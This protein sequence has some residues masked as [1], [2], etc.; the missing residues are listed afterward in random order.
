MIFSTTKLDDPLL[1]MQLQR[2]ASIF[3]SVLTIVP[4]Y[5]L[6]KKF[7]NSHYSLIGATLFLFE[8]HIIINSTL[9]I[10]EP[11]FLFLGISSLVFF[12]SK[13]NKIECFSFVLLGLFSIIRVEGLLFF[14]IISILY[15]V[16]YRNEKKN[17]LRL[18]IL[19][20]FYIFLFQGISLNISIHI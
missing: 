13:N 6:C 17:F 5:F 1:L 4:I 16:K 11:I 3:I 2:S 18:N 15:F 8:P 9:G 12:L 10:T 19:D 20:I 7:F 14:G